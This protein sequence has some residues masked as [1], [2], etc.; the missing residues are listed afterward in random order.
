MTMFDRAVDDVE[1][2]FGAGEKS[3]ADILTVGRWVNPLLWGLGA[4]ALGG[5]L[6]TEHPTTPV[7][8]PP[9]PVSGVQMAPSAPA[10][11]PLAL[12]S[13]NAIVSH[14]SPAR[15]EAMRTSTTDVLKAVFV[16]VLALAWLLIGTWL[17]MRRARTLTPIN[18]FSYNATTD[19][20][21]GNTCAPLRGPTCQRMYDETRLVPHY[22]RRAEFPAMKQDLLRLAEVYTDEGLALRRLE[23]LPDRRY[24]SLHDL[25]SEIYID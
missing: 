14:S 12:S 2:R 15:N 23:R 16:A 9:S 3:P 6:L 21:A 24:C 4:L 10:P 20:L 18:H 8:G 5:Y 1:R 7:A 17:G 25:I 22:L 19:S 13:G 11:V